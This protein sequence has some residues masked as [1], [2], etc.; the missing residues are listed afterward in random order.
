MRQCEVVSIPVKNRSCSKSTRCCVQFVVPFSWCQSGFTGGSWS[1]GY[2]IGQNSRRRKV[3]LRYWDP[4]AKLGSDSWNSYLIDGIYP[5]PSAWIHVEMSPPYKT[6]MYN[7]LFIHICVFTFVM[8]YVLCS[9]DRDWEDQLSEYGAL[10]FLPESACLLSLCGTPSIIQHL[11]M[12]HEPHVVWN[13]HHISC[14]F[15]SL[16]KP[17]I[18]KTLELHIAGRYEEKPPWNVSMSWHRLGSFGT[19]LDLLH[20]VML[21]N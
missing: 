13:H 16:F 17:T 3:C 11:V 8:N 5:T 1:I 6:S 20:G 18:R 9:F 19:I 7:V 12:S 21:P 14:L 10:Y 2:G 15:N 4:R